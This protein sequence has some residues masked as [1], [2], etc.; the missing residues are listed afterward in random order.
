MGDW[1]SVLCTSDRRAAV[2]KGAQFLRRIE[3]VCSRCSEGA[4]GDSIP[5]GQ[6]RLGTILYQFDRM[7]T[8]QIFPTI[9]VADL[10][11]QMDKYD[12]ARARRNA[13]ARALDREETAEI[14][15]APCRE[16][17]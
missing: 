10:P 7:L 8:A 3:A 14:G 4:S 15:R 1:S 9:H 11:I 5:A 16:S 12:R 17:V 6:M 2:T 13:A